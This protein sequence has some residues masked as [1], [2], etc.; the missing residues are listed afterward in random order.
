M[1]S[2][3]RSIVALVWLVLL[4]A[5]AF[6]QEDM[7][8]NVQVASP[9]PVV[10]GVDL[11][12]NDVDLASVV[13]GKTVV[14][15]FWSIY[16]SDC[17]RELDDLRAIR[18]E[19]PTEE[20]EVVA[21]NTDSAFPVSRVANFLRRYEG[22]RGKTL[23]VK[24]IL[25]RDNAIV[26]LLGIRYI[27]LMVTVDATGSVSSIL[28]GYDHREDRTRLYQAMEQGRVALGAWSEGP[29][30]KLRALLRGAGPDGL[31]VEWGS[32]RLEEGMS[33]FGWYDNSGWLLDISGK[34]DRDEEINRVEMVIGDRLQL[35]LMKTALASVGVRL[36]HDGFTPYQLK[37]LRIPESPMVSEN[38]WFR[39]YQALSFSELYQIDHENSIWSDDEYW[40]GLV[41][42]VDLGRLRAQLRGLEFPNEPLAYKL[43]TV[44]DYDFKPRMLFKMFKQTSYRVY[45]F[46]GETILY[47]GEMEQLLDELERLRL[48][49]VEIFVEE[50]GETELR[51]EVF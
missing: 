32:F 4:A 27:P 9:L 2:L 37:G 25:D 45:S 18:A 11:S 17:I 39:L 20:V 26:D 3:C 21:I 50:I 38:R 29:K 13:G 51:V 12:G 8:L 28:S 42:D 34:P 15:S 36:P 19:F 46:E 30:A 48:P 5:I 1:T 47:Y 40:A 6:A 49:G 24:H 31:P 35:K 41:G 44:S 10:T 33:L 7:P 16:C 23:N 14:L 22:V 43:S